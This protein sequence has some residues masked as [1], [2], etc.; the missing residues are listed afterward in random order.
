MTNFTYEPITPE[1]GQPF[2]KR[3]DADGNESWIPTDPANSDFA[4]F[5]ETADGKA[6]LEAQAD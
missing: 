4:A 1:A 3:T 5:L 6:Y 2:I